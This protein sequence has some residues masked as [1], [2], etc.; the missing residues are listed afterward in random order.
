MNRNPDG[1]VLTED[2][3]L[4]LAVAGG[5]DRDALV[6]KIASLH[7][8]NLIRSML[9]QAS[10]KERFAAFMRGELELDT[11]TQANAPYAFST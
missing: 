9:T 10:A 4:V 1:S 11:R 2:Q 7:N 5:A 6:S 8:T 3:L